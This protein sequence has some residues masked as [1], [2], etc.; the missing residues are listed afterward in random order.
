MDKCHLEIQVDMTPKQSFPCCNIIIVI[1][2]PKN[3]GIILKVMRVKGQI[4]YKF[5]PIRIAIGF[6]VYTKCQKR[7]E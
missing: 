3:T 2:L 1:K 6:S 4:S 5:K 7:M